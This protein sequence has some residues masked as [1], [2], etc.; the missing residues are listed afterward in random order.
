MASGGQDINEERL[1]NLSPLGWGHI[2][3]T[4][5]YVWKRS[6]KAAKGRFRPSVHLSV[7]YFPFPEGTPSNFFSR[8]R[9]RRPDRVEPRE[10][11]DTSLR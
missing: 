11:Q 2:N 10:A 3:L 9:G 7:R 1:Q 6:R 5:D 4:G 8:T